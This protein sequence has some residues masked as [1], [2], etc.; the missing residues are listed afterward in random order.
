MIAGYQ[1]LTKKN[2]RETFQTP[3]VLEE[4]PENKT[5]RKK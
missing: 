4:K 5:R 1:K 2:I 3:N